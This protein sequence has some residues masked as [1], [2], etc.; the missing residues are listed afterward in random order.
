MKK[1]VN[2]LLARTF[3]AVKTEPIQ[4]PLKKECCRYFCISGNSGVH[5]LRCRKEYDR[6]NL[7]SKQYE[8]L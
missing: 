6:E 3:D 4:L 1:D 5:V 8:Y 7:K 2:Y